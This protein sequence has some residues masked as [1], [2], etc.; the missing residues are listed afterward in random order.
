ML[1]NL[2]Y[3]V[4]IMSKKTIYGKKIK[5][6]KK[7]QK[8]KQNQKQVKKN[9][10]NQLVN[11]LSKL[12]GMSEYDINESIF[13]GQKAAFNAITLRDHNG[14]VPDEVYYSTDDNYQYILGA[15]KKKKKSRKKSKKKSRK[16]S[17]K[18]SK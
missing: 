7:K 14:S 10:Y 18:K 5:Q 6:T 4:I 13:Q 9:K 16:K 2:K 8:Q 3:N 15:S 17:R 11:K 12:T 1:E